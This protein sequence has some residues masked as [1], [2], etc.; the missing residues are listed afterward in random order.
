MPFWGEQSE[1]E[2]GSEARCDKR[3][4][5]DTADERLRDATRWSNLWLICMM[6]RPICAWKQSL[7]ALR[8]RKLRAGSHPG[9]TEAHECGWRLEIDIVD[10]KE[11]EV[12]HIRTR[13]PR[14]LELFSPILVPDFMP[15]VLFSVC[16]HRSW[17]MLEAYCRL[18]R[19]GGRCDGEWTVERSGGRPRSGGTAK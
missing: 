16:Q 11:S 1:D 18:E 13:S 7:F 4:R 8:Q 2:P 10:V 3:S 17:N 12:E 15:V 9:Y 14:L 6:R 19:R 5:L